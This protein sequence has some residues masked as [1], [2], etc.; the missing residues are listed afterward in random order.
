MLD[1]QRRH[2]FGGDDQR[3]RL[4]RIILMGAARPV[5]LLRPGR[6]GKHRG[7]DL[8]PG[9]KQGAGHAG[10]L[11]QNGIEHFGNQ[12]AKLFRHLRFPPASLPFAVGHA[13]SFRALDDN[14]MIIMRTG[15]SDA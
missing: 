10:A 15:K 12:P 9:G 11:C 7:H 2:A 13:A 6:L 1:M 4:E 14:V 3:R 8:R 5:D